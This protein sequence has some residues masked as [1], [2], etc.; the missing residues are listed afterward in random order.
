MNILTGCHVILDKV[1]MVEVNPIN[2]EDQK[3]ADEEESAR[4]SH[5]VEAVELRKAHNY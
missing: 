3:R 4:Y 2:G 5:A 1:C